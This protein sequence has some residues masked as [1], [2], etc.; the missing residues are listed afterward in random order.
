[1]K[2]TPVYFGSADK[3]LDIDKVKK[4]MLEKYGRLDWSPTEGDNE[5]NEEEG[6]RYVGLPILMNLQSGHIL[7]CNVILVDD[8]G[9]LV[10][11]LSVTGLADSE[12]DVDFNEVIPYEKFFHV[13]LR[14]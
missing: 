13:F 9:F 3:E 1:M 4:E 14:A 7:S 10:K 2:K 5:K 12:P 11:P 6:K 8:E